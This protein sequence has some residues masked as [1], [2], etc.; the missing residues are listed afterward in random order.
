M[1]KFM[2]VLMAVALSVSACST[3]T[4]RDTEKLSG[5]QERDASKTVAQSSV[6]RKNP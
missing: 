2:A 1:S 4:I 3:Q 5:S 6:P